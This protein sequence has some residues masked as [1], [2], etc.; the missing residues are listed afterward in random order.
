MS[1]NAFP[2]AI[3]LIDALFDFVVTN[4][5]NEYWRIDIGEVS[6]GLSQSIFDATNIELL[7]Y[8]ISMDSYGFRHLLNQH[9]IANNEILRGQVSV[10]KKDLRFA[11]PIL[12]AP[13]FI[14][15]GGQSRLGHDCI[16]FEKII[17]DKYYVIVWEVRTIKSIQKLRKKKHRLMLQTFYIRRQK[18]KP[19]R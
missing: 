2:N 6:E 13:D 17:N 8:T 19:L 16:V 14:I 4:A 9:G 18:E 15:Y 11:F 3:E 10:Q 5:A 12:D 7:G 1:K